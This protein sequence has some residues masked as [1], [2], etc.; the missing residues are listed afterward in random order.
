MPNQ[1]NIDDDC[2]ATYYRDQF[3]EEDAS[4]L[5]RGA[6]LGQRRTGSVTG[7]AFRVDALVSNPDIR[8]QVLEKTLERN[9]SLLYRIAHREGGG[10]GNQNASP[11]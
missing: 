7:L 9:A 3:D 2:I 10:M 5:P 4:T 1:D 6:A 8:H 11:G